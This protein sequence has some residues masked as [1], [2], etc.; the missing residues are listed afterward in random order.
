MKNINTYI[1]LIAIA[2]IALGCNSDSE[3]QAT[4][5]DQAHEDA[6]TGEV[7]LTEQ[8]F[9]AMGLRLDSLPQRVVSDFIEANGTLE[10]PPQH[11]ASV[12]AIIGANI[13]K[14]HVIEGD[15]VQKGEVLATLQHPDLI[16]MQTAY[17]K[18]Y[19]ELEYLE[20]EKNRQQKLYDEQVGSGKTYQQTLAN[21]NSKKGEVAGQEAELQLLGINAEGIR[22]GELASSVPVR[23]PINGFVRKV[24][25][26]TGQFVEPQTEMFDIVNITHIHADFMVFEKDIHKVNVGQRVRFTVESMPELEMEA[27][28][29]AVGKSFERDPKALHLHAEIE[30]KEGLLLPGMYVRGQILMGDSSGY[31]LPD[32]AVVRDGDRSYIFKGHSH[33]HGDKTEWAFEPVEVVVKSKDKGWT[34]FEPTI[35]VKSTDRFVWNKAYYLLAEMNKGEEGGEHRH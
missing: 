6:H 5:D 23:S 30:Q 21:Y 22:K 10:V 18:S 13:Q 16:K 32:A 9:N 29:Y 20:Q 4:H 2:T 24:A 27:V 14:I 11:E 15:S 25:V 26:K 33:K 17:V 34:S 7:M 3:N 31:A 19:S 12:T 8:Q 35:T 28:I 1:F